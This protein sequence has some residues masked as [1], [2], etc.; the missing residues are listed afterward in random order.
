M[1]IVFSLITFFVFCKIAYCDVIPNNSHLV[2]K[3]VK[4]SNADDFSEY[5]LLAY[6]VYP[7][8][9]PTGTYT[10][11]SNECIEL[12]YKF[13]SLHIIAIKNKYL[14][15]KNI[16]TIDWLKDKHAIKVHFDTYCGDYYVS[17]GNPIAS[18]E[19]DYKI[20]ECTDTSVVLFKCRELVGFINGQ[21]ALISTYTYNA[22]MVYID[23]KNNIDNDSLFRNDLIQMCS[24]SLLMN[25]L[26]A[27]LYTILIETAFL[28][29]VFK[30]KLRSLEISTKRL[31]FTGIMASF[32][33]LPYV[34]FVL[35]NLIQ[36]TFLYMFISE[37]SVIIVESVIIWK[38]LS[39][40][41]KK[42]L[43]LAFFANVLSFLN[44]LVITMI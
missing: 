30:I 4:I 44:G 38:L 16:D 25:F 24:A 35:P 28:F 34:W 2:K 22:G 42:A 1:R 7:T 37:S 33:T 40:D 26:V 29:I 20:V 13:N 8:G 6:L 15:G 43:L 11:H 10:I 5:S 21:P 3:C 32:A 27:L 9:E 31:L 41:Y 14:V 18:V 19:E 12:G 39:I 36:P 23:Q 17:N